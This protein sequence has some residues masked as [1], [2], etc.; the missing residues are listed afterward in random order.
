[1]RGRYGNLM[2]LITG[3]SYAD[4]YSAGFF[5]NIRPRQNFE[6]GG[7]GWGAWE[8]GLRYSILDTGD[9]GTAAPAG[10][11]V[12]APGFSTGMKETTLG[13]KWIMNPNTRFLFNYV[14][15]KYDQATAGGVAGLAP[16]T[17]DNTYM[18][19]GQFD[20]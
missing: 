20:F 6:F 12:N 11:L 5:G 4:S 8:V 17:L 13:L 3:E 2:W 19:R 14:R 9:L 16:R 15:S 10:V 1:M 18:M 7:G